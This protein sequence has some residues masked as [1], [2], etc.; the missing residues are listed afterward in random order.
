MAKIEWRNVQ[1][2]KTAMEESGYPI[3]KGP[4]GLVL[5]EIAVMGRSNVGKSS[6]LNDLFS[7][8]I[9]Y[10]SSKPGKTQGLNFFCVDEQIVLVDLPGFGYAKVPHAL[11]AAWGPLIQNY[12]TKRE[13]LK[14][15]L[16]LIDSRRG[17][18][19]EESQLIEW[20]QS[21]GMTGKIIQTKVDKLSKSELASQ[22]ALLKKAL[23]GLN[24]PLL[25]YSIKDKVGR[26]DLIKLILECVEPT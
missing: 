18:G 2:V 16:L 12:L 22:T 25:S 15:L 8:K 13:A 11:R 4:R 19:E 23:S 20:M 10:T 21:M 1:F 3:L 17:L 26:P 6:L 24:W 5:P 7:Q 14:G 9:V